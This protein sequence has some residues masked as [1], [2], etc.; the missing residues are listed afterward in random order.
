M[1]SRAVRGDAHGIR[2]P[3][4]RTPATGRKAL[5]FQPF[6]SPPEQA[7]AQRNGE[8]RAR[9]VARDHAIAVGAAQGRGRRADAT[10][11]GERHAARAKSSA[12]RGTP[13]VRPERPQAHR[14]TSP[15]RAGPTP[16]PRAPTRRG[17]AGRARPCGGGARR[18]ALQRSTPGRLPLARGYLAG[19]PG[20]L[21]QPS[22]VRPLAAARHGGDAASML[23]DP[24]RCHRPVAGSQKPADRHRESDRSHRNR[25]GQ[26]RRYIEQ[27]ASARPAFR[28][29]VHS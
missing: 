27:D 17:A 23:A 1:R 12:P 18:V 21:H 3:D 4:P 26:M 10:R 19:H 2:A 15:E 29:L 6:R 24:L 25:R 22:V 13:C 5:R 14:G 7:G 9:S 8:A 20:S 16:L 11:M 28:L